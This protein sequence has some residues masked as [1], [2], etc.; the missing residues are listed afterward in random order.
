MHERS[1]VRA[2]LRQIAELVADRVQE[3]D[4]PGGSAAELPLVRRV[5]LR[6][7]EF[8]GVEICL[9]ELAFQELAVHGCCAAA[10]LCIE[11]IPLTVHCQDCHQVFCPE[12]Y[13]FVCQHCGSTRVDVQ[14]GDGIELSEIE[15]P[16]PGDSQE[17]S[18]T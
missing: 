15:I 4:L 17:R 16:L 8:S 11:P 2:L 18:A 5:K 14:Q 1:L 13:H 12:D 3:G 7:G 10:Q 9:L 6:V